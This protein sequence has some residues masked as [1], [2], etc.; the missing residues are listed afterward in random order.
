MPEENQNLKSSFV[1]STAEWLGI[2][3]A[4]MAALVVTAGMGLSEE[5]WRNF[6]S[7]HLKDTTGGVLTAAKYMG[8]FA[9][10]VNLMEGFGYIIG[11]QVAHRLGARSA[12]LVSALPMVLGFSILLAAH[13]PWLIIIGAL[14][15][16]NW[17]PLSV[18]A[19]FEIV[20]NEVAQDR[21]TIAFSVQSIQK[22]MPKVLGPLIGGLLMMI[23][24]W[25]NLILAFSLVFITSLIQFRLLNKLKPTNDPAKIPFRHL[26]RDIPQDLR[27]LLTAEIILR[28]GD[29]F[30]RDFAVLY[31]V[32]VLLRSKAEAGILLA[33]TSLTAL[34]T[35]IPIGK[36]VDKA[37]SPRPFIGITFALFAL[38]PLNLVLLPRY[39][40][41]LGIPVMA[42]LVIVFILNGLRELGEPARKALISSGFPKETR[43]RSIGLYWGLRSFAFCPAPLISYFLWSKIGPESTFLIGGII[44]VI[45]TFWFWMRVRIN[46]SDKS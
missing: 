4:M 44:G 13:Q 7:L 20:G 2:N 14:F 45:G 46:V 17:E 31:V 16:T 19:T 12:M 29:W 3:R 6:L 26:L 18:P 38:F 1:R 11:G 15:I 22:R 42:A 5:I 35:Y 33:V 27:R 25:L 24:Y 30:V 10:F 34:I 28:W 43:A 36:L 23:G 40:P 37:K 32:G 41:G 39:L 9:V 21:R 8:I